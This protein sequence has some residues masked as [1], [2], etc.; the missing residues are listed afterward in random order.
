MVLDAV[1]TR[2]QKEAQKDATAHVNDVAEDAATAA[3][4]ADEDT[5]EGVTVAENVDGKANVTVA[6]AS[7][8]DSTA[9]T[10]DHAAPTQISASTDKD[11]ACNVTPR[12]LLKITGPKA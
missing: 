12:F 2:M 9:P 10:P 1:N 3:A 5:A 6:D 11:G 8:D 4:D 7:T